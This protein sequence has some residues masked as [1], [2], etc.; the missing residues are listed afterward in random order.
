MNGIQRMVS[1][2]L[3]TSRV[4]NWYKQ[5]DHLIYKCYLCTRLNHINVTMSYNATLDLVTEA[6]ASKLH[7]L[8][9]QQWIADGV[10]HHS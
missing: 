9:L 1:L 5:T 6:I 3:F 2:V 8:P 4:Q 10:H 7:K